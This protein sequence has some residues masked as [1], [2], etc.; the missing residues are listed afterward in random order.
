MK[1]ILWKFVPGLFFLITSSY[2]TKKQVQI[3]DINKYTEELCF[4]QVFEFVFVG[5]CQNPVINK[6]PKKIF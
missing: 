4:F 6:K 3:P 5:S 2:G 1:Q